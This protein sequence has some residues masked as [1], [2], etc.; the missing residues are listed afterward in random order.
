MAVVPAGDGRRVARP[1]GPSPLRFPPSASRAG[2]GVILHILQSSLP[3]LQASLG[4]SPAPGRRPLAGASPRRSVT[5]YWSRQVPTSLPPSS[6]WAGETLALGLACGRECRKCGGART[7]ACG[8][9]VPALAPCPYSTRP[10]AASVPEQLGRWGRRPWRGSGSGGSQWD[11]G[12]WVCAWPPGPPPAAPAPS[13]GCTPG[14]R[15]AGARARRAPVRGL[16]HLSVLGQ[17]WPSVSP[18][19]T[20]GPGPVPSVPEIRVC[21]SK[22]LIDERVGKRGGGIGHSECYILEV[23]RRLDD[24]TF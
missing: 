8:R 3:P 23:I 9:A 19:F 24:F 10:S 22:L 18:T 11:H 13:G 6:L 20:V 16:G 7:R 12:G 14:S 5:G 17:Q 1:A 21:L 2:G 4:G 15:L